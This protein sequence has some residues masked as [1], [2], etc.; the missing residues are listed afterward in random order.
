MAQSDQGLMLVYLEI[1]QR[2]ARPTT[3]QAAL[4]VGNLLP[5]VQEPGM[6]ATEPPPEQVGV[7]WRRIK[8][9]LG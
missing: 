8:G 1:H 3:E 6:W 2:K 4:S 5:M 7:M 9:G